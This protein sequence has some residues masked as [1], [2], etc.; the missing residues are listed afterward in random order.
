MSSMT[1]SG[2]VTVFR[3]VQFGRYIEIPVQI[4]IFAA[5]LH[6]IAQNCLC[7]TVSY[8]LASKCQQLRFGSLLV[9]TTMYISA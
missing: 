2:S 1:L 8:S 4:G 3:V 7:A 5:I 6:K 9:H